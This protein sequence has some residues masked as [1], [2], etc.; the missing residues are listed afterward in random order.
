ML[1]LLKALILAVALLAHRWGHAVP[2]RGDV[3]YRARVSEKLAALTFDDGPHPE[4]TPAILDILERYG[5]RATF[6]MVGS[7]VELYPEIAKEVWER[8]HAIGNHTYTHPANLE[9]LPDWAIRREV[10]RSAEAIERATGERPVLFRPPRG[11]FGS[12][13]AAVLSG[14]HQKVVLWTVS[15]DHHEA[16]TP[17]EM[18]ERVLRLIR[19]GAIVLLHDG[20]T[21]A[22]W[23][24]VVAT[25]MLIEALRKRG[26]R[27]VT[28]P[29]LLRSEL[30]EMS[31]RRDD[32]QRG[33]GGPPS[34]SG[35]RSPGAKAR[36]GITPNRSSARAAV[37]A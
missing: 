17:H 6:F 22:R 28:V 15:A 12:K 21:P 5:V 11:R 2:W 31:S 18:A 32:V 14:A 36:R 33:A 34:S 37:S 9:L 13:A 25:S 3:V 23:K 16:K 27:L 35:R 29:E 24:D 30:K 1:R 8:G 7:S 26:Y 4:F 20:S 19:P 10:E